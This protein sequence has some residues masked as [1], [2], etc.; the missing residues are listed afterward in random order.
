MT[1]FRAIT[2][3]F[4]V[5]PQIS[6]ADVAAARAEG[7]ELIVNNRPDGETPDQPPGAEIA[8]AAAWE[9]LAYVE[10]PVRGRP[11]PREGEAMHAACAGGKT[12]AFC[13]TGTRSIVAWALGEQAAG[14]RSRAELLS[15]AAAAGYDLGG[16][17]PD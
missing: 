16:V 8:A 13:R 11:G 12:L 5:S 2:A 10:I 14:A 6:P 1:D 17:L 3:A 15:L 7:F 4:A 9:G